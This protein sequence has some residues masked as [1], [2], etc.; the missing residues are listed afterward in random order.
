MNSKNNIPTGLRYGEGDCL[1][2][3]HVQL[4]MQKSQKIVDRRVKRLQHNAL[5]RL[6]VFD[7]FEISHDGLTLLSK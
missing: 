1:S 4:N 5:D 7:D 2:G 3:H 6:P